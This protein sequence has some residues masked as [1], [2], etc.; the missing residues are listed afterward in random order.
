MSRRVTLREPKQKPAS[1]DAVPW[2]NP[3]VPHT[4]LRQMYE[5]MVQ[6]RLLEEHV[7]TTSLREKGGKTKSG[8]R[9]AVPGKGQ[10]AC[11]VA[12]VQG[13]VEGDLVAEAQPGPG[14]SFLLGAE[15]RRV[16][17]GVAGNVLGGMLPFVASAQERLYAALGAA[18]ALRA[19]KSQGVV[20]VYVKHGAVDATV[21]KHVLSFASREVLPII[22]VMLPAS[23][24]RSKS[25]A[26]S[27]LATSCQMPGIA[28]DGSDA[29]A[30]YR[31]AQ[32][33]LGR[34]R[35]GGGPVLIEC[36]TYRLQG[37]RK[38]AIP[39]PLIDM[40]KHVLER[41]AAENNWIEQVDGRF[42]GILQRSK[43]E[44]DRRTAQ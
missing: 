12:V 24:K 18:M 38:G 22:L 5:K 15:L 28:V 11:R 44:A 33:S 14:M 37:E 29:I 32:E 3:L 41:G 39:D 6:L 34:I 42:A 26:V 1:E 31:V 7:S 13:L 10:E 23:E 2:E 40:K 4:V 8:K 21:W 20:V 9:A 27:K 19:I 30:L 16:L 43:K 35:G 17:G 25:G 36:V